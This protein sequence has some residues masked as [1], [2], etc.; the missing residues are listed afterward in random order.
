MNM[1]INS[2]LL[3]AGTNFHIQSPI[4]GLGKP[5]IRTSSDFFGGRD[6]GYVSSQFYGMRVIVVRGFYAAPSCESAQ[7]LRDSLIDALPIRQKLPLFV[8]MFEGTNYFT[9]VFVTDVKMDV[10]AP[11]S[12]LYQL[13]LVAPDP[14]LYAAGDGIDPESGYITQEIYKLVGGGYVMPYILPVTWEAGETAA[15]IENTGD[16]WVY[17][18]ITLTG[19]YTNPKVSNLTTGK[20][21]QLNVTTAPTDIIV[22]DMKNRTITL[23]GGSIAAYRSDDSSWWALLPGDNR[24]IIETSSGSD[25]TVGIV[26]Y[27]P[28]VEGV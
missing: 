6:G 25:D 26:K 13:T 19:K 8:Q 20:I 2:L 21:V 18:T 17:P 24:V 3:G 9:E 22:I 27:R 23:N 15:I 16:I 12:G 7:G 1:R 5:T 14:Y 4:E 10:S 28:G 11:T